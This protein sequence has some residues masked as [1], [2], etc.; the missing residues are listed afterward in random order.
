MTQPTSGKDAAIARLLNELADLSAERETL[1]AYRL[2]AE[3]FE[4]V[5]A[6]ESITRALLALEAE[7]RPP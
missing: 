7:R 1:E 6:I 5:A 4:P 3:V 2:E